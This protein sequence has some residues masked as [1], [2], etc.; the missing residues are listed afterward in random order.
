MPLPILN[1]PPES[2]PADLLRYFHRTALRRAE[3]LAE[4]VPLD[5]GRAIANPALADLAEANQVRD[6]AVPPGASPGEAVA[7]VERYFMSQ[8]TRCRQWVLNPSAG[9]AATGPLADYLVAHGHRPHQTDV[10]HLGGVT[11]PPPAALP[12]F[13]IIPARAG[14]RLLDALSVKASVE[15]GPPTKQRA[16]AMM[17]RFDD[18]HVDGLLALRDGVPAAAVGVLAVGD[19]GLIQDLYVA[20]DFRRQGVGRAM[21]GR[22]LEVC[23]RSVF[24]HV[25]AETEAGD[26]GTRKLLGEAGFKKAGETVAYRLTDQ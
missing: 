25:F 8:G 3:A 19:L 24:K 12:G 5:A 2:S 1:L 14:Y 7:E 6:A 22:A 10:F 9:D 17:L 26:A 4:A 23:A 11:A 13:T 20:E 16:E 18:P 15:F 21:L